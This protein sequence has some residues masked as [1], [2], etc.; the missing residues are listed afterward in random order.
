MEGE[1]STLASYLRSST[2][3]GRVSVAAAGGIADARGVAGVL[4]F[5]AEAAVLGTRFL[6]TRESLAQH[7]YTRLLVDAEG[8]GGRRRPGGGRAGR[9]G[10]T[11]V[12]IQQ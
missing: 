8:N 4:A 2:R 6:G 11:P 5:G 10:V 3:L 1:L 9:F 12:A 7:D